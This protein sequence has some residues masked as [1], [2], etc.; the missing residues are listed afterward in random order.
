MGD[1]GVRGGRL[2]LKAKHGK[3]VVVAVCNQW[4]SWGGVVGWNAADIG[5]RGADRRGSSQQQSWGGVFFSPAEFFFWQNLMQRIPL[6]GS[7]VPCPVI[8]IHQ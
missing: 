1:L 3:V 4:P 8:H 2:W 5:G 6:N 7:R